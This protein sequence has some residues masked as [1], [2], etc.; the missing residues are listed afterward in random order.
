MPKILYA[1]FLG[2]SPAVSAQFTPKM[3]PQNKIAKKSLNLLFWGSSSFK[4]IDVG[5]PEKLVS[6]VCYD[7]QQVCAYLQLFLR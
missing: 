1:G 3:R 6:I 2:L 7:K 5:I 4:V